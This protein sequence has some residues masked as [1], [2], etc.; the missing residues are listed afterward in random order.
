MTWYAISA[1]VLAIEP[2]RFMVG[3]YGSYDLCD[4]TICYIYSSHWN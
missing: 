2:E 1:L 4:D 3:L